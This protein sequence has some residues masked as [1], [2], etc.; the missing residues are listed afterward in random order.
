[1]SYPVTVLCTC[2]S[3]RNRDLHAIAP[4][5][6][7]HLIARAHHLRRSSSARADRPPTMSRQHR[8][9]CHGAEV[10]PEDF[11]A[12]RYGDQFHVDGILAGG[13]VP[14]QLRD[15]YRMIYSEACIQV[16]AATGSTP[17]ERRQLIERLLPIYPRA[18]K[19]LAKCLETL[20]EGIDPVVVV[21][22]RG[23]VKVAFTLI[24]NAIPKESF[25]G[26]ISSSDLLI[27]DYAG[28]GDGAD[29][30][31][32]VF[33]DLLELRIIKR[34]LRVDGASCAAFRALSRYAAGASLRLEETGCFQSPKGKL[35]PCALEHVDLCVL[36]LHG[37]LRRGLPW[38]WCMLMEHDLG[39]AVEAVG[40]FP[41]AG[42][43]YMDAA[44]GLLRYKEDGLCGHEMRST[45]LGMF[46]HKA[47]I[48]RSSAVACC[49][50]RSVRTTRHSSFR[51]ASLLKSRK[52]TGGRA[53][54]KASMILR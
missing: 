30:L 44:L 14:E 46:V 52:R 19:A 47:S 15:A 33:K 53:S 51:A 38:D 39:E 28:L 41:C 54:T 2:V 5:E 1:M 22:E 36:K 42:S 50:W 35:S 8:P 23:D 32:Q 17:P 48:S 20:P 40:V 25:T 6:Q 31:D 10:Y 29:M 43:L 12:H 18:A 3:L 34:A 16:E 11:I 7:P 13:G 45:L 49:N 27:G 4:S 26:E 37:S 9:E 21:A 24:P